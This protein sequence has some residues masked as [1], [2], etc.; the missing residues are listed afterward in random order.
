M[1]LTDFV[2]NLDLFCYD[3]GLNYQPNR[4]TPNISLVWLS[5]LC[6]AQRWTNYTKNLSIAKQ[7][8]CMHF[9]SL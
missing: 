1:Q 8:A 5:I 6:N 2:A 4:P 9:V 3:T 7:T